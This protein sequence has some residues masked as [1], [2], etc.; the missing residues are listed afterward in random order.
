MLTRQIVLLL[1]GAMHFV[2]VRA[3]IIKQLASYMHIIKI[4]D[5]GGTIHQTLMYGLVE[6]VVAA[7]PRVSHSRVASPKSS[8]LQALSS[9]VEALSTGWAMGVAP[10]SVRTHT[11]SQDRRSRVGETR[12]RPARAYH[13][14]DSHCTQASPKNCSL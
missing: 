12:H 10:S 7:H 9:G 6:S 8:L 3:A 11:A 13:A 4:F 1:V 5:V 14:L 2:V